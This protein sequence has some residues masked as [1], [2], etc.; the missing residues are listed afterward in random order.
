MREGMRNFRLVFLLAAIVWYASG[1]GRKQRRLDA[2][3]PEAPAAPE[4]AQAAEADS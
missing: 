4:I 3:A 2:E 1:V